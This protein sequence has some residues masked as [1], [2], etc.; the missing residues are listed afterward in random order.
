MKV[1]LATYQTNPE[2]HLFISPHS[3]FVGGVSVSVTVCGCVRVGV[4]E[5][6]DLYEM[7]HT[8][9]CF[10]VPLLLSD[11]LETCEATSI[12]LPLFDPETLQ[13]YFEQPFFR[14]SIL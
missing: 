5:Q 1:C 10:L 9:F 6:H 8:V 12:N 3:A 4:N 14:Q 7:I 2:K 13:R 11:A